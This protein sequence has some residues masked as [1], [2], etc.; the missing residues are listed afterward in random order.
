VRGGARLE[1]ARRRAQ[2][3]GRQDGAGQGDLADA[4]PAGVVEPVHDQGDGGLEADHAMGRVLEA[5]G[6]LGVGVGGVVGGDDVD[7]AG[8]QSAD[9]GV[10]V[11]R[12]PERRVHLVVR[13]GAR[14][15]GGGEAEVVRRRLR[16]HGHAP[17]PRPAHQ[18]Q[19]A[20]RGQ[21]G[22]VQAAVGR[23]GQEH[24]AG[25]VHL[26]GQRALAGDAP[27]LGLGAGVHGA[28]PRQ[29]LVLA[30]V[31]DDPAE[32]P[33]DLHRPEHGGRILDRLPV[34]G[35]GAAAERRQPG[36]VGQLRAAAPGGDGGD[37]VHVREADGGGAVQHQLVH[38]GRVADGLRVGHGRHGGEPAAD[39]GQQ[40]GGDGL[41]VFEARFAQVDVHV[42]E[43]GE[44]ERAGGVDDA[45]GGGAAARIDRGDHPVAHQQV[46]GALEAGGR[47]HQDAVADQQAGHG[48]APSIDQLF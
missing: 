45:V 9:Q 43:A 22:D 26:L 6:L 35:E 1:R 12:R 47:I 11:G 34:V 10:A 28:A 15:V 21:V 39:G 18:L 44:D 41:L 8:G 24:V 13:I 25:D 16:R 42:H 48:L 33:H 37:G 17:P 31:D 38:L 32:A 19:S 4:H 5:A 27:P 20:G 40:A 30:V 46:P 36:Q 7:V 29:G 14:H 3:P 2:D 23:L